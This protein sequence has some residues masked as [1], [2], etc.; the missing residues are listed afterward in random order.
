MASNRDCAL[1]AVKPA[2]EP[3]RRGAACSDGGEVS[4]TKGACEQDQRPRG[5]VVDFVGRVTAEEPA[6]VDVDDRKDAP[7]LTEACAV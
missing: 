5:R 7:A 4:R 6:E 3:R 2:A 1:L